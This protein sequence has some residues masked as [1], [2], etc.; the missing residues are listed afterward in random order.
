MSDQRRFG[1]A[2][3]EE[4]KAG[5]V[6]DVYFE[7]AK[8]ILSTKNQDAQVA[9]E[10]VVKR[11][12][13]GEHWAVSCGL[14]SILELLDGMEVDLWA[15][16]EGSIF[17]EREP[18]LLIRGQYTEIASYQTALMGLI[19]QT[20]G[21]ATSAAHCV[22]ASEGR[23]VY[24]FGARGMHP[25]IAPAI[26]RAAYIGG[27]AG[28]SS[29]IAAEELGLEPVGTIPHG[30]VLIMGDSAS[31][32]LAFD[33]VIGKNVNRV[34]I[35]DTFGDEKFEALENAELLDTNI[36]AVRLETPSSRRGD[37]LEIAREVRWELDTRGYEDIKILISGGVDRDNIPILNEVADEYGV[38]TPISNA[39]VV[40]YSLGI[41]EVNGEA[42]AKRG[43]ES[44]AKQL[45]VCEGCGT[46]FVKLFGE[47]DEACP[48]CNALAKPQLIKMLDQGKLLVKQP[49]AYEIRER[50]LT[51]LKLL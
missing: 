10:G 21:V 39:P 22:I 40:N 5:Q 12:A 1:L 4:I 35:V 50:V 36:Y 3:P 49:P 51:Q 19:C 14:F 27:C 34:A 29:S 48:K 42:I 7:R 18:V 30:L 43:T 28:V 15:L 46:R 38:D 32:M 41:V 9:F 45:Y 25:G 8:E 33:E 16:P 26:E 13:I 6:T 31:A 20:S 44:G 17:Y 11:M 2:R 24:S 37:M 47:N 23:P